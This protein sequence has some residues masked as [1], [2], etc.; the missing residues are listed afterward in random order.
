M[1]QRTIEAEGT[2]M[3]VEGDLLTYAYQVIRP[4]RDRILEAIDKPQGNRIMFSVDYIHIHEFVLFMLETMMNT[5]GLKGILITVDRPANY[6]LK[7]MRDRNLNL[8][9]IRIVDIATSLTTENKQYPPCVVPLRS[10]FCAD[11]DQD[12]LNV[13]GG[14]ISQEAGID[15]KT[16]SFLMFDNIAVLDH[17]VELVTLKRIFVKLDNYLR[18]FPHLKNMMIIDKTR[19]LKIYEAFE[20]WADQEVVLGK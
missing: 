10:P 5:R 18:Y 20:G 6:I 15:L 11:L 7:L 3:P 13:L 8:D 4:S 16:T 2:L 17:Y 1:R 9:R 14:P 19:Q 12:L